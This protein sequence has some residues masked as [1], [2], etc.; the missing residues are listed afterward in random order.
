[1]IMLERWPLFLCLLCF[2]GFYLEI[3]EVEVH[4]FFLAIIVGNPTEVVSLAGRHMSH[5]TYFLRY[6]IHVLDNYHDRL[7]SI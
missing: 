5:L 4:M 3:S 2:L 6:Y 1:M 7:F